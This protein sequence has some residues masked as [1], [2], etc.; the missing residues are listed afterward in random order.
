[1]VAKARDGVKGSGAVK[2]ATARRLTVKLRGRA[3]D[4]QALRSDFTL[5]TYYAPSYQIRHGPLQALVRGPMKPGTLR[6]S[7]HFTEA[8]STKNKPYG[9]NNVQQ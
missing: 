9:Y 7:K 1:M 5:E 8:A 6:P 3:R 4:P 2:R